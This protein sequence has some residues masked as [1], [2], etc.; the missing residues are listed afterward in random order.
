MVDAL[1][2]VALEGNN[3]VTGVLI[4]HNDSALLRQTLHSARPHIDRLVVVDGA[5][6]WIAPFCSFNGEDPERSTDGLVEILEEFG[7]PYKYITGV[8]DNE[9]HKRIA[10][11]QASDTDRVMRI[12]A[13]E[14]YVVNKERLDRFWNSGNALGLLSAPLFMHDNIVSW[15]SVT[16]NYPQAPIFFNLSNASIPEILSCLWLIRPDSE[17]TRTNTA[18]KIEDESLGMFHHLSPLRP[19]ENSYRRSRFY[20]LVSMRISGRLGFGL[21]QVFT[22]DQQLVDLIEKLD[23]DA[24]DAAFRFHRIASSFP[25]LKANQVLREYSFEDNELRDAIHNI[26]SDMLESQKVKTSSYCGED[27]KIFSGR[28]HFVDVTSP[29]I[30]GAHTFRLKYPCDALSK[31]RLHLDYGDHRSVIEGSNGAVEIP[32]RRSILGAK[33]IVAEYSVQHKSAVVGSL[34]F[35]LL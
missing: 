26:Y 32:G 30:S 21:N 31:A 12:D 5:Y 3:G 16:N 8:W 29:F 34:R 13:D 18:V 28:S 10:S 25:E 20:C 33:R 9:T 6:K 35:D 23:Q 14:I 11:L 1:K 24:V 4:I 7:L 15:N 2:N 22:S 17:V 27:M 19:A